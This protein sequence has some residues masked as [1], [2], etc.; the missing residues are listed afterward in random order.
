MADGGEGTVDAFVESGWARVACTVCGPH[1]ELVDATFAYS[2]GEATAVV[3]M[4]AASGLALVPPARRDPLRATTFGTG[5]LIRAA[6]DRGARRIVVAIGGSA[7]NDGGAGMLAALGVG[8]HDADGRVLEPGGAALA[9]LA[10][11]HPGGLDPRIRATRFEIAAD[12]DNPLLGPRGATQVFGPQKGAS[13]S[14][15]D[16]LERALAGFADRTA[17]A[18]GVDVRD[19]RGTGAAGGLGFGLRAYLGATARPGVELV[20]ELRGLREALRGAAW[21][22]TGEG[23]IDGQTLA[24]KTVAGVGAL[25]AVAGA[26]TVAFAGRV[27]EAAERAL[28]ARGIVAVPIVDAPL[29]LPAAS[30]QAAALLE[31]AA[32]RTARLIGAG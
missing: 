21:C 19:E 26:R 23:A 27:D 1:G 30:A 9:R 31:R 5:E 10:R 11:I 17:D 28:A 3:E 25:A 20:A 12:V 15:V 13:S 24:G 16:A 2:A 14:D 6:L 29:D 4:A 8:L 7:T 18:L 22:F 32:E